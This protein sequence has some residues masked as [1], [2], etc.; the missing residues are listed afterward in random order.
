LD[1]AKSD[2]NRMN[3]S[4]RKKVLLKSVLDAA[5]RAIILSKYYMKIKSYHKYVAGRIKKAA[6][7]GIPNKWWGRIKKARKVVSRLVSLAKEL[8]AR[9]HDANMLLKDIRL[10]IKNASAVTG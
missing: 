4:P 2:V 5:K 3:M 9:I 6:K 8:P 1:K 7:P 10:I